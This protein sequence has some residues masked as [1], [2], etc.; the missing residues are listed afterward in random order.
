MV[1]GRVLG[2]NGVKIGHF[3]AKMADFR[4]FWRGIGRP[5]FFEIWPISLKWLQV[6]GPFLAKM[7]K[8]WEEVKIANF[9]DFDS[10]ISASLGVNRGSGRFLKVGNSAILASKS[11]LEFGRISGPR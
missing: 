9:G 6:F 4:P 8:N 10:Q 5:N 7:V 11:E 3:G 2:Q 1:F